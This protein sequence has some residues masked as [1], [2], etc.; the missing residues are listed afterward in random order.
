MA[1]VRQHNR[2]RLALR[3]LEG[4]HDPRMTGI[5]LASKTTEVRDHAFATYRF[6]VLGSDVL[7]VD[8]N[9]ILI[10]ADL[11]RLDNS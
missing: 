5:L 9:R 7:L 8:G 11:E 4:Q 10:W 1:T 2:A 3:L 6:P